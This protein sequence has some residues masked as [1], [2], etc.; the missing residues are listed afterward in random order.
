[1]GAGIAQWISARGYPVRLKDVNPEAL[2]RG[3]H[4][5]EKIYTDAVSHR[6]FTR[7][8]ATAAFVAKVRGHAY[9]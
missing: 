7:T 5:I 6:V 2:A 3:L 1:M 9:R 8:E 4:A